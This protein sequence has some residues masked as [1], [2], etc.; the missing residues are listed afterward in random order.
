MSRNRIWVAGSKKHPICCAGPP[1]YPV[2]HNFSLLTAKESSFHTSDLVDATKRIN[3]ILDEVRDS[4]QAP[5]GTHLAMLTTAAGDLL[6]WAEGAKRP[7]RIRLYTTYQSR[8]SE[9]R[10][11]LGIL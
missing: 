1:D 3:A 7:R 11:V 5:P 2:C 6:V 8:E 9:Q 4:D 10:Q